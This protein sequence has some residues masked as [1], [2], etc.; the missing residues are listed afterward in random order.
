MKDKNIKSTVNTADINAFRGNDLVSEESAMEIMGLLDGMYPESEC[1]LHFT[2]IFQLIIAVILS[3]QT[4]DKSVN[5][6]T[7]TL[8][9]RY[10]TAYDLAGASQAD[11]EDI[12]RTIG[13]YKT[14]SKNIIAT[15]KIICEQYDGEVPNTYEELTNLPGVGRKTANVVL[16]VGFGEQ[17]IAVDTHVFRVS[18]RIGLVREKDVLGTEKALMKLLPENTWSRSHHILIFH[19]RYCCK[20]R[21]PECEHCD[22]ADYCK[23]PHKTV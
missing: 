19:G 13:M 10:P 5:A 7:P 23:Y 2:D 18:N 3:A 20:A 17:R 12:I 14:K 21:K 6:V 22:I 4:T 8:F 15:A 1:E 11:V 16:A 9:T